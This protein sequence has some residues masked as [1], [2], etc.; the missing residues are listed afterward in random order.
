MS[1]FNGWLCSQKK[2][3]NTHTKKKHSNSGLERGNNWALF[4]K[5]DMLL[6]IN[7]KVLLTR[8][9]SKCMPKTQLMLYVRVLIGCGE[10][11]RIDIHVVYV[12]RALPRMRCPVVFVG[13][14]VSQEVDQWALSRALRFLKCISELCVMQMR[15]L[16]CLTYKYDFT[17]I[18]L[19]RDFILHSSIFYF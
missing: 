4:G 19:V 6:K 7:H 10:Q 5:S 18:V 16:L 8:I 11:P 3:K 9:Q 2:T 17:Y 13:S 12:F 1:T 14:P 15:V